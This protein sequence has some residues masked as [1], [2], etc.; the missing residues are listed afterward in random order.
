MSM[1][2]LKN[3]LC[4]HLQAL[5][6]RTSS[7]RLTG[8]FAKMFSTQAGQHQ[9]RRYTSRP[10]GSHI[11]DAI[12]DKE[13]IAHIDAQLIASAQQHTR[14]RLAAKTPLIVSMR[15]EVDLLDA[16]TD[17]SQFS[18]HPR[19]DTFHRFHREYPTRDTGLI[20]TDKKTMSRVRKGGNGFLCARQKAKLAPTLYII[21]AILVDDPVPIQKNC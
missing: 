6:D 10:T 5:G 13:G 9:Q 8:V 1:P 12:A 21:G 16:A 19:V 15:A 11:G 2:S 14:S 4:R 7:P 3:Y 17:L 18:D 20:G